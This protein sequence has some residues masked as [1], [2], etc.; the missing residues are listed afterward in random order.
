[1]PQSQAEWEAHWAFYRLTVLQ[2]DQAWREVR[3]LRRLL[4]RLGHRM[5]FADS[6]HPERQDPLWAAP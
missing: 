3:D 6:E 2:R 5:H 1:M 4:E